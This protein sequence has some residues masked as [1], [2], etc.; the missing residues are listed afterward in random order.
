M[1]PCEPCSCARLGKDCLYQ[2]DDAEAMLRPAVLCRHL[3]LAAFIFCLVTYAPVV[4][5]SACTAGCHLHGTCNEE[6]ARCDC[7]RHRSGANCSEQLHLPSV[8][9]KY[10]FDVV[11]CTQET[12]GHCLNNCTGRGRCWA[13][14]CQCQPGFYGADCSL[15][16]DPVTRQPV[17]L[18]GLG[19]RP[20]ARGPAIYIYEVPPRFNTW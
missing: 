12:P 16:L 20:A 13:G 9:K 17:L 10:G 15:S 11:S 6:L 14:W 18:A 7:P 4:G 8:C 3:L 19:Y 2:C 5:D 1:G